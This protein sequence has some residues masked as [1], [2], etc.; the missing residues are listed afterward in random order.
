MDLYTEWNEIHA[1][2]KIIDMFFKKR[3]NN[4]VEGFLRENRFHHVYL[5]AQVYSKLIKRTT[6]E[7]KEQS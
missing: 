2:A 4:T 6:L 1:Q 5:L 7:L 3:R